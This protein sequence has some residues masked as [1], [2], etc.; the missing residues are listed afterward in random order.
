MGIV[1]V[2][3]VK[4]ELF[5]KLSEDETEDILEGIENYIMKRL[6]KR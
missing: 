4:D 5:Q 2:H 1:K 3:L 6:H